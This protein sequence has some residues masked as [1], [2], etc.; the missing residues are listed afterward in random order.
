MRWVMRLANGVE[1]GLLGSG[2]GSGRVRALAILQELAPRSRTCGKLRLIS[3]HS[4]NE[5][6]CS[7]ALFEHGRKYTRKQSYKYP[8]T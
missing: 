2:S 7:T 1:S 6:L 5:Q 4:D 8:F 3:W